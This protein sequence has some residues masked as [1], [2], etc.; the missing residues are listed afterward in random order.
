MSVLTAQSELYLARYNMSVLTAQS[1][2]YLAGL[3]SFESS[4][5]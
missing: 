1:E 2:L 3:S 5:P 4:D